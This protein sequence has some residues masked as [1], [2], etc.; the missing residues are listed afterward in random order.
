[1]MTA[2][3]DKTGHVDV[4]ASA[5]MRLQWFA[6]RVR[7]NFEQPVSRLL[8]AKSV[9]EFLPLYRSRRIW[10]D[11]VRDLQL[12]LFPGYVFCRIPIEK[13]SLVLATTGVVGLVGVQRRPLPI[14]DLEMAGVRRM[15]ETQCLVEPWPLLRIGQRVRVRRGP[16]A[17]VEGILLKARDSCRLVVSVT[18]LG[19]SVATE[20]DA[21]YVSPV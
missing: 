14:D 20:I 6:L 11:R 15:V 10:S 18:L 2:L 9:E 3:L 4:K 21:A 19:R 8:S 12:P 5:G 1:M 13:C 16:L 7:S 17:G